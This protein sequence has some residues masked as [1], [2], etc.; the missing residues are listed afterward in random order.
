MKNILSIILVL[1]FTTAFA[2]TKKNETKKETENSVTRTFIDNS[3]KTRINKDWSLA[4]EF[5]S[6]IG[7]TVTFFPVQVV[8]LDTKNTINAIELDMM[9]KRVT[10]PLAPAIISS[11]NVWIDYDEIDSFIA[12]IENNIVPN[13]DL[14]YKDKSSEFIFQ[15]KE[16]TL[17]F[18]IHEKRQRLTIEINGS[19]GEPFWTESQVD[20]FP[21]LLPMLKK[22]KN[23]EL[24]FE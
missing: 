20:K 11:S 23:K 10:A 5:K 3:D 14:K 4:A 16:L 18:L 21:K 7:E 22:V 17:K 1:F 9:T 13:L 24:N 12:F 19:D 15:A 2:Q 6:G 8:N